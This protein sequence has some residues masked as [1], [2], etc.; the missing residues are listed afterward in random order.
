MQSLW[1]DRV[2]KVMLRRK[3]IF[4]IM[5]MAFS[6]AVAHRVAPVVVADRLMDEF[7]ITG[8]LFGYLVATYFFVYTVMQI[9]SGM[10][11]D[12]L[13]PR[14]TVTAGVALAGVG[15]ILIG[16]SDSL[17]FLFFSRFLV[18]LGCSVIFVSLLKV[19]AE[20]FRISE[21]ATLSGVSFIVG[22]IGNIAATYPFAAMVEKIGWRVSFEIV[23]GISII[24]AAFC[25]LLV[26]NRPAD[27]GLPDI[28]Q[29]EALE[30]GVV[31]FENPEGPVLKAET[32]IG[33][34]DA[35]RM[36]VQNRFTW[37]PFFA[38]LL[39]YGSYFHAIFYACISTYQGAGGGVAVDAIPGRGYFGTP[40]GVSFGQGVY[41][42]Q[43][44]IYFVRLPV[45]LYLACLYL[46]EQRTMS[47]GCLISNSF[48]YG[49]YIQRNSSYLGLR[50]GGE[51]PL[52]CRNR[53]WN[54]ELR[55]DDGCGFASALQWIP[56]G[57]G[58]EGG[59]PGRRSGLPPGG[60]WTGFYRFCNFSCSG[61]GGRFYDKGNQRQKHIS[62]NRI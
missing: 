23:G 52:H 26:R 1:D 38:I 31:N 17:Q 56:F 35:F 39:I 53:Q 28:T 15:S 11:A 37:P 24:I 59:T 4:F 43:K 12:Y 55:R 40:C 18:G 7:N 50:Q 61:S 48:Y 3:V 22:G 42:S 33:L 57:P 41:I 27:V 45:S 62:K 54:G 49:L 20:W 2:K 14:K 46:Y 25:W 13:G 10:L 30:K 21:F 58:V 36:A 51:P 47:P 29:I 6:F 9:P 5:S 32:G 16:L 34:M 8:T 44:A 60:L 19:G